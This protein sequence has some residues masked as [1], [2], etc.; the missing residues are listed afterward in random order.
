[1]NITLIMIYLSNTS[2][3]ILKESKTAKLNV[4]EIDKSLNFALFHT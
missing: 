4:N 1:M 2:F 3:K